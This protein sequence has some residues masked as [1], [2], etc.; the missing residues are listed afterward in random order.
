METVEKMISD[1]D[2]IF[3]AISTGD[4]DNFKMAEQTVVMLYVTDMSFS[5]SGISHALKRLEQFYKNR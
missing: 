2:I 1:S 5:R 4:F 3:T